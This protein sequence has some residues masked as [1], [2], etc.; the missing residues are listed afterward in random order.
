MSP[1]TQTVTADITMADRS[2]GILF[3]PALETIQYT[4]SDHDRRLFR[5]YSNIRSMVDA[6]Q[7][8][9]PVNQKD[10]ALLQSCI[11]KVALFAHAFAPYFDVVGSF[12]SLR[13]EWPGCF[14]GIIVLLIRVGSSRISRQLARRGG[15]DFGDECWIFEF[16]G[17]INILSWS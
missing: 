15:S 2:H 6:M 3:D 16:G 5:H 14:W 9:R 1:Q 13:P 10:S 11:H 4:V 17:R 7:H 12:T 8:I